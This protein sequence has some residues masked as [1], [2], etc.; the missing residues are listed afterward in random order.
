MPTDFVPYLLL[1]V[2]VW[3]SWIA[4][5]RFAFTGLLFSI[6]SGLAFHRLDLM[7]LFWIGIT[8]LSAR[9]LIEPKISRYYRVLSAILFFFLCLILSN[10][11]ASGFD[12]LL[13]FNEVHFSP[14]SAAFRMYLNFD[15]TIAG[16]LIY[17]FLI[18][19]WQ[20]SSFTKGDFLLSFKTLGILLICIIPLALVTEY[21]KIDLKL[22]Q[23]SWLWALNNLFFVCLAEEALFRGFVQEALSR[24]KPESRGWN[25][26]VLLISSLLFGLAHYKGGLTYI[27]FATLAGLFYGFAYFKTK[28][29][30]SSI[31]VHFGLNSF[32][33]FLFSYPFFKT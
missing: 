28:R 12:N 11:Y 15:K 32:H 14:D 23:Q 18:K 22:H 2:T 33:F 30:E 26:V 16:I 9:I 17:L 7:A 27:G 6:V 19:K 24:W 21:V 10:H 3:L 8:G 4:P 20:K 31:L 29:I 5:P 1:L 13:V 25:F